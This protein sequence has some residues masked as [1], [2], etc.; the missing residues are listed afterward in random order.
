VLGIVY[1]ALGIIGSVMLKSPMLGLIVA[2]SVTFAHGTLLILNN[3]WIRSITKVVCYV[4]LALFAFTTAILAP[5]MLHLGMVGLAFFC[6][7][8]VDILCLI[9]MIRAIDDVYFA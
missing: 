1:V 7:F 6:V 2:G 3:D 8:T 5:Y 4:R 9:L